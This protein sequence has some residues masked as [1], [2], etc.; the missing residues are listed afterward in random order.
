MTTLFGGE[1]LAT[2]LQTG[3]P[4]RLVLADAE[5]DLRFLTRF[6]LESDGRFEVV[7]E[8]GDGE[9]AVAMAQALQPHAAVLDMTLPLIGG[10]EAVPLIKDA[11]PGIAVALYSARLA[12]RTATR[13][14]AL[15]A[16]Y[17]DIAEL[18]HVGQI[19][20]ESITGSGDWRHEP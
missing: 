8:A 15:G 13:A 17:M 11:V 3:T 10:L 2:A 4:A 6:H 14:L 12:E 5:P 16:L 1:L 7:G 18:P 9:E 19:L 20:T